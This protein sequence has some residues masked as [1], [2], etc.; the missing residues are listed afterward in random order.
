LTSLPVTL[1]KVEYEREHQVREM[2]QAIMATY[3]RHEAAPASQ[4]AFM[5]DCSMIA[6]YM[7]AFKHKAFA[8]E[9][10]V[11]C[12]HVV[13][14]EW[15]DN[16]L[17]FVDAGG[18]SCGIDVPGEPVGFQVR[19]NHLTAFLDLPLTAAGNVVADLVLGPKNA[20]SWGNVQL[21]LGA[22]GMP[23][24][25]LRQSDVPYR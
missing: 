21:F 7:L 10:E 15:L 1:L 23:T 16:R 20:S 24:V 13:N 2:M 22:C 14:V 12:V 8:C 25:T 3:L 9:N 6:T 5:T 18:V 11:R 19:E 17:S 4:E